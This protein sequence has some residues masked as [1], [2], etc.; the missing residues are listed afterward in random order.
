MNESGEV[1]EC[2]KCKAKIY[3]SM[4]TER[5]LCSCNCIEAV[6]YV[7]PHNKVIE[8]RWTKERGKENDGEY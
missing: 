6:K 3:E 8:E 4:I 2:P 1:D 5:W 7:R